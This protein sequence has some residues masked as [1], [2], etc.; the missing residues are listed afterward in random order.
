MYPAAM[1]G[2]LVRF[3]RDFMANAPDEVGSA[4]A[5]ITAPP[6]E[7][8]PEPVRGQ[9][10]CGVIVCYAGSV[11]D[12][13]EAL[14]PLREFGPPGIDMVAPMPYVA[15]QQLIDPASPKGMQNYWSADFLGELPDE[16]VDVLVEHATKP[17]SPLTQI[18]L[19]PGGGAIARIDDDATAFGQRTAPWNIHFLS[20][21][22]DPA[23]T[24]VNIAYTRSISAAMKP[25]TTGEVYL[26]F[27]GDEGQDRVEA[28]FGDKKWSRLR[29]LK[30]KWD[31]TN[32]FRHNQNIPPAPST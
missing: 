29:E 28:G 10:V 27:I 16:A 11:E 25:W 30:A 14:R 12:G 24:E 4:L 20:M 32:L 22:P 2:D 7:F 1:A 17:V 21:W 26:N 31:P 9:P 8:V 5:F 23:D 15:V 3:Y 19:I 6:E 13:E 18:L